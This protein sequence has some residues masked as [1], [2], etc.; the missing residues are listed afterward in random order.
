MFEIRHNGIPRSYRDVK[1]VAYEAA[2][3]GKARCR[4][5]IIEMDFPEV[6]FRVRVAHSLTLS[7]C[8]SLDSH[9]QMPMQIAAITIGIRN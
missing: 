1:S 2:R 5:E 3:C 7:F 9:E 4:D 8:F 6:Y